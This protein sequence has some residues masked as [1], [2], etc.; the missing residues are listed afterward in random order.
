MRMMALGLAAAMAVTV[1]GCEANNQT[2][3]AVVGAGADDT[4]MKGGGF[5][6]VLMIGPSGVVTLRGLTITGGKEDKIPRLGGAGILLL[7]KGKLTLEDCVVEKNDSAE[8]GGIVVSPGSEL[9]LVRS[10]VNDN[11]AF[12]VGGGI[13]VKAGGR[14]TLDAGSSVSD[15]KSKVWGGGI[16]VAGGTLVL[17]SGSLI[18]KNK[19]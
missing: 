3:G 5:V 8:G 7:D 18:E 12:S 14:A 6:R 9:H 15:N 19:V 2:T 1:A 4:E 10:S 17:E 13:I 11:S 16:Y